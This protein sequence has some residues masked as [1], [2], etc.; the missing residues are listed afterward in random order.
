MKERKKLPCLQAVAFGM[1]LFIAG[2][3]GTGG[4]RS[5]TGDMTALIA[6]AERLVSN[7]YYTMQVWN[8]PESNVD[9]GRPWV[10]A[11]ELAVFEQ[12]VAEAKQRLGERAGSEAYNK[13]ESAI[14]VFADAVKADGSNPYFRGNP[15]AG[16][17][18]LTAAVSN[19]VWSGIR[20]ADARVP[21]DYDGSTWEM[22]A[23][24]F[25]DEGPDELLR[26]NY[27]YK[28][29][30]TFGGVALQTGLTPALTLTNGDRIEFDVYYP[31]SAQGIFMRW[32]VGFGGATTDGYM[33]DDAYNYRNLNPEWIGTIPGSDDVWLRYS[34]I[35]SVPSTGN[36]VNFNL[37][38]HGET[39]RPAETGV[40]MVGNVRITKL[41]QS[42][43]PLPMAVYTESNLDVTPIRGKYNTVNGLFMV[44]A[45]GTGP[46]ASV[47]TRG[48]HYEIFV[49]GNNLKPQPTHNTA[50]NWLRNVNGESIGGNVNGIAEYTLPTAEYQGIRDSGQQ[51]E[52]KSHA[53]VLAWYNQSPRWMTQMVPATLQQGYNG[54]AGFYGLGNDVPAQ[55]HRVSK[56]TAR[57]VQYNH[58]M[59]VMRHFL[60]TGEK[61]GSSVSRGVIP[62]HSWDV[63]NE[64][65]HESR[66]SEIIPNNP[67]EWRT[68]LKHTNWLAAM[69]DDEYDD[70]YSHYIY[71]LFKY[72]HIAAPNARMIQNIKANLNNRDVIPEYMVVDGHLEGLDSLTFAAP[73]KLVYNDYGIATYSKAR[74]AYNMIRDL[75]TA[76]KSDPL[77]D[78][79]NLIEDMGIQG[80][81]SLGPTLASDNQIAIAMYASLI[82]QGLL[83]G[84]SYSELDLRMPASAPGGGALA[85]APLNVKQA[86]AL[87]YQYALLYKLFTKWAPY[88]DHIISWG[89]TGSG[90][91]GSYV[92]FDDSDPARANSG[93]Y[94][95]M[96]PD[97][98]ILGHPYLDSWFAGEYEKLQPGYRPSF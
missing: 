18:Y 81:D 42:Q 7:D 96:N 8:G 10:T 17:Q 93:Y 52:Y 29:T 77:Y 76:W 98:F 31:R 26:I 40:V 75:N 35:I 41:D 9:P 79:R 72:A 62:F 1:L 58:I 64:E 49:N 55:T 66:F 27:N 89:L 57:R 95:V 2:C 80:H 85:P 78:G 28:A 14:L 70:I 91:Q 13:L 71:L 22:V 32:R 54:T 25:A 50:P 3:L 61:Y 60:T 12:A 65:I 21:A 39:S 94:G 44:G 47:S 74:T 34:H 33:R 24:P 86:D 19:G 48:R 6:R 56:E 82:D 92:L 15:G 59:Y 73:P 84:I 16:Q 30:A 90:W 51:G 87:G 46:V 5:R 83:D 36:A 20:P 43:E 68:A 69:M 37:E 4:G 67:N 11:D 45:I 23:Y 97:M 53:H 63:L 88:M 38:L